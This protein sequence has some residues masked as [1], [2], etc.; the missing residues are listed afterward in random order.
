MS[1]N[2]YA[3]D[4]AII[5]AAQLEKLKRKLAQMVAD[6]YAE[7]LPELRVRALEAVDSRRANKDAV[8]ARV[9]SLII[10]ANDKAL[11]AVSEHMA[12]AAEWATKT[13]VA[14]IV[15]PLGGLGIELS[16]PSAATMAEAAKL[17]HVAGMTLPEWKR[18][19][20]L[21][22]QLNI[23]SQLRLAS[24]AGD[25]PKELAKRITEVAD[26]TAR[27]AQTLSRT[28][29]NQ[30]NN[31]VRQEFAKRNEDVIRG[32]TFVATLDSRTSSICRSLDGKFFKIGDEP[33]P[34]LHPNCRSVLTVV[35][36]ES[37]DI[38]E[39]FR[40]SDLA[41]KD[42]RFARQYGKTP[43]EMFPAKVPQST[44]YYDWL[45]TQPQHV[46]DKVLGQ[47]AAELWRKGKISADDLHKADGTQLT[48]AELMKLI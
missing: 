25:S 14:D 4:Q 34:P 37:T 9:A 32:Y 28:A 24:A 27:N 5:R 6:F 10:P 29:L 22:G 39:K 12:G 19:L 23:M 33:K 11:A 26:M 21:R 48:L 20:D 43:G 46:A 2:E 38:P 30:V 13:T 17:T 18:G 44:S 31:N 40:F 1:F 15:K 47:K 8:F 42:T 16:V 35:L 36:K 45:K 41:D 7:A 3:Q